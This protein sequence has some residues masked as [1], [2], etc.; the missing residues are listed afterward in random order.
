[1]CAIRVSDLQPEARIPENIPPLI[2]RQLLLPFSQTKSPAETDLLSNKSLAV[3]RV[4]EGK[5][6]EEEQEQE[7]GYSLESSFS[8]TGF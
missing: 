8:W 4:S 1:M 7:V 3:R 6:E 2:L 5:R